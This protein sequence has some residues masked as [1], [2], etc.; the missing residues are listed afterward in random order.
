[1]PG[2][3]I[4]D[5]QVRLYMDLR[6]THTREAAAAKAALSTTTGARLDADPR[7]PT[8]KQTPHGRRRPDPL[9]AIWD[10][11]IVPMLEAVPGLRPITILG[12]MLRR[13]RDLPTGTRRTLERRVRT[14]QALHGPEREVIFRQEHP[15][16]KQGL[17]DFTE[18]NS[19][20]VTVAGVPLAHR[21]YH[22]R[23]AFSGYRDRGQLSLRP[24]HTTRHAGPHRAVREVE[25]T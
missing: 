23:L 7:L 8:Q 10:S 17:S 20:G 13:H 9:A 22:F 1:M 25:V 18:G 24:S 6:R 5:Q 16:G 3:H 21:L 11:E 2:K 4:T 14:W 12:E 19:L 15:P